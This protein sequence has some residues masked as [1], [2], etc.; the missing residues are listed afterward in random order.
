M[1]SYIYPKLPKSFKTKWLKF[2]RSGKYVQG[3]DSLRTSGNEFCCLGVAC[4]ITGYEKIAV[5]Y[6]IIPK[7]NQT[8]NRRFNKVPDV[9]RGCPDDNLVVK[10]LVGM[11]DDENWSFN[12]IADWIEEN[13]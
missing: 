5:H 10:K 4:A 8:L 2:L 12:K 3:R 6:Q 13:L 1:K 9:L 7:K 11:N